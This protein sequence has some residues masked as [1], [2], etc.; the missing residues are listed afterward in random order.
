MATTEETFRELIGNKKRFIETL[1]VVENKQRQRVPFVY[2]PI[3]ADADAT[4]TGMDIWVKPSQV[5]FSTE[6]IAKRLV[7]TLTNPGTNTVLVAY[8]DFIT[9]RLLSKVNFFYS[10]LSSLHIPGFPEIYHS[11]TYEKVFNFRVDG[12]VISSSSIY[13]AS[14]R[15]K[16]AGRAETIHHLLLDEHAFYVPEATERIIVPAMARIP[17]GGTCDS[18]S[19]PNGEENEF[20]QWYVDAKNG[21]SIFTSHFYTW[22]MH[23]EY[24]IMLGD[25]RIQQTIPET[26]KEEFSLSGDEE[27]LMFT[28]SLSFS[29]IRWRRWMV[30]VMESLRRKGE[31]RTLFPQ[32]FP[33]D[34]VSCFLSTGEMYYD[35]EWIENIAKTCYDA[36]WKMNSLNVWYR[37]EV[38]SEGRPSKQYL[39]VID[40]G[41]AKITQSAI[42]VMS[43]GKDE[44]GNTIPVW[45]AR[46]A[47]WYSPEITADKAVAASNYYHRAMIVWEAN[48][49]GL[50]I[51]ELLKHRRPIYFRQDIVSGMPSMEPGWNTNRATKDY[52]LQQVHKYLPSLVCHDIELVRQL[53][54]F[55]QVG[56][57]IDIIGLDDIHDTLAIGLAVHNPN[58]LKRGYVGRTG[59]KQDWGRRTKARHSVALRR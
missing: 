4:E 52:M 21:N 59:Y 7:D 17:P 11:S 26:D 44:M 48:A 27:K 47:G 57:K 12:R 16:T 55:R 46:D 39:V 40:P 56:D 8:E 29:Q 9:E 24:V 37:P 18:F 1:L 53:R 38:D 32:E 25:P 22:F 33:E 50:A 19:T 54:N 35:H 31:V 45:C 14:A 43:F 30:K 51:T 3:Q 58:P 36:K 20:H 23:P 6:R 15:S 34:D 10:H 13:I 42:A 28:N 2:N 49:H 5:G 41:Q